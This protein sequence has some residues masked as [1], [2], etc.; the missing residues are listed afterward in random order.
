MI[1]EKDM[2]IASTTRRMSAEFL[3]RGILGDLDQLD[4]GLVEAALRLGVAAPVGVG[5]LDQQLAFVEQALQDELDV[6]F[7]VTSVA[8]SDREILVVD[9][10]REP[11]LVGT[12]I[13]HV[14]S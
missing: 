7:S 5:P 13:C 2:S 10:H 11:L 6:K 12:R 1:F 4:G 3:R 8:H 9:K 14:F